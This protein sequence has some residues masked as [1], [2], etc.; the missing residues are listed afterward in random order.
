MFGVFHNGIKLD[1]FV[2]GYDGPDEMTLM[3]R[4]EDVPGEG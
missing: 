4:G 2:P 1:T 3:E